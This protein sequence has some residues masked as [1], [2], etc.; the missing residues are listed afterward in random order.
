MVERIIKIYIPE[1]ILPMGGEGLTKE[2]ELLEINKDD[3]G[4]DRVLELLENN[5]IVK[6]DDDLTVNLIVDHQ[7]PVS[8]TRRQVRV[9]DIFRDDENGKGSID[10]VETNYVVELSQDADN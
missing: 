10:S 7:S 4:V 6:E 9:V 3:I 8:K 2:G 5:G 1:A